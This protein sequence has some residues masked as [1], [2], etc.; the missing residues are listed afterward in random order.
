MTDEDYLN[1]WEAEC[2]ISLAAIDTLIA[3]GFTSVEAVKLVETS[4]LSRNKITR[5]Q[6]K[7]IMAS[8]QAMNTVSAQIPRQAQQSDMTTAS[9]SDEQ[10][11][12]VPSEVSAQQDNLQQC[13][14][15]DDVRL[16]MHELQSG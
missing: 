7:L 8:V 14:I 11:G 9:L 5:G 10:S 4:D 15:N 3:D 6:Q 2:K 16:L 12:R 13:R 1:A